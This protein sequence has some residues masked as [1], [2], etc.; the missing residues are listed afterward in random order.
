MRSSSFQLILVVLGC[1]VVFGC[2][3]NKVNKVGAQTPSARTASTQQPTGDT[4]YADGAARISIADL[5]EKI[6]KHEVFIIDVRNQTSYDAGHIPGSIMIPSGEILNH[7]A[8]L[9]KDKLIV[10]YCS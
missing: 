2:S 5:Q 7:L 10:T 8:E 9:P 4:A 1:A 6:K 3:T